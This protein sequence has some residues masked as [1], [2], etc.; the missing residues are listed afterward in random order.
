MEYFTSDWHLGESRIGINGKPNLFYR[1]FKSVEEQDEIITANFIHKSGFQNGDTLF[2]LGDV[3]YDWENENSLKCLREIRDSFPH[4]RFILVCGNY[5]NKH[6]K[7]LSRYFDQMEHLIATY[8]DLS[9]GKRISVGMNHYP[10]NLINND[11]YNLKIVGHIH[12]LWKVQ[13]GMINV[14][15]DAWHFYPIPRETLEFCFNAMENH[16][17]SNVFPLGAR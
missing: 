6:L 7:K 5:D 9:V 1:P 17:D 4:S 2:H 14:S 3:V 15:V 11:N 10:A 13:P 16:Y 8:W 12:G